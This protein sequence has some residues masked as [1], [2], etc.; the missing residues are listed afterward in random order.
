MAMPTDY[1]NLLASLTVAT[2]EKKLDWRKVKEQLYLVS[3]EKSSLSIERG[4]RTTPRLTGGTTARDN[5]RVTLFNAEGERIET[6]AAE[7]GESDFSLIERLWQAIT[8]RALG[9]DD[10]IREINQELAK[11]LHSSELESDEDDKPQPE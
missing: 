11:M 3:F 2:R 10:A 6:F 5:L 9:V 1:H 8:R 4:R 7:R